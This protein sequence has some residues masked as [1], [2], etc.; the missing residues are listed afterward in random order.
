M[1]SMITP[2]LL[3]SLR[4]NILIV[5]LSLRIAV[6]HIS[7]C[8][9]F[10]D[11]LIRYIVLT[12]CDCFR[13]IYKIRCGSLSTFCF[14]D[15]IL[16]STGRDNGG[17]LLQGGPNLV[18]DPTTTIFTKTLYQNITE[19]NSG[20]HHTVF[21]N[22]LGLYSI[23]SNIFGQLGLNDFDDR[24]EPTRINITNV[25]A[26]SCGDRFTMVQ[27]L[28]GLFSTGCNRMGQL[29]I[30]IVIDNVNSFT[31]VIIYDIISFR[32][33]NDVVF[34][35]TKNGLFSHGFN[36]SNQL[37]FSD[38]VNRYKP[39][40]IPLDNVIS[41][42]NGQTHSLILTNDGLYI[43]QP[44]VYSSDNS[45]S[46]FFKLSFPSVIDF[47]LDNKF[48]YILDKDGLIHK[49]SINDPVSLLIEFTNCKPISLI[50]SKEG[51]FVITNNNNIF[52]AGISSNGELGKKTITYVYMEKFTEIIL[53]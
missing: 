49:M 40:R 44:H 46:P 11:E 19:I 36:R 30:D 21:Q 47:V 16:Y 3:H 8:I 27:T 45:A 37:G 13:S 25:I 22:R 24:I 12:Y 15:G 35:L 28:D 5:I 32:C 20:L 14:K 18:C 7:Y 29:G 2:G 39:T 41:Y 43:T 10:P 42:F 26:L 38:K 52:A 33:I 9:I 23:G 51:V 17:T 31:K 4:K 1:N 48:V 53:E 6:T 50:G 34:I